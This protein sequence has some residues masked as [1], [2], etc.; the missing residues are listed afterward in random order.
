MTSRFFNYDGPEFAND[1]FRIDQIDLNILSLNPMTYNLD[2]CSL[3]MLDSYNKNPLSF[4]LDDSPDMESSI[5]YDE[6]I[7]YISNSFGHRSD[8]FSRLNKD[9]TNVLFAGCSQTFGSGLPVE[10]TWPSI[11]YQWMKTDN[12]EVS[13]G[14]YQVLSFTGGS[15]EKIVQN[16]FKYCHLFG[17]PNI[18][19]FL[20]PDIDRQIGYGLLEYPGA[21]ER[22]DVNFVDHVNMRTVTKE[23]IGSGKVEQVMSAEASILRSVYTLRMLEIFCIANNIELIWNTWGPEDALYR[24]IDFKKFRSDTELSEKMFYDLEEK[25]INLPKSKYENKA[26][27]LRHDGYAV[28]R[29]FANRMYSCYIELFGKK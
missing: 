28:Q 15:I 25:M 14:P 24:M 11:L 23:E 27:D 16:I 17:N 22:N 26:R 13:F 19:Y 12:P 2:H 8:E 29:Y 5:V 1:R 18:I 3:P 20:A 21:K 4:H 6:K 10:E 7:S 9:K